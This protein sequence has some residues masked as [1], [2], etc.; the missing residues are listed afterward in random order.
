MDRENEIY[1]LNIYNVY[2]GILF[3]L[4]KE[5]NPTICNNVDEPGRYY[6]K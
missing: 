3:N 4:E 6:A 1:T 5:G 2:N